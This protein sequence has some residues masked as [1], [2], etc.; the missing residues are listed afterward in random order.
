MK[1]NLK[2]NDRS[3][4]I[5]S[6]FTLIELLVVIAIIAIL[7]GML[8]PALNNARTRARSIKCISNLKQLGVSFIMYADANDS[9]Y[10]TVRATGQTGARPSGLE[11]H[12]ANEIFWWEGLQDAGVLPADYAFVQ[13][14]NNSI[15]KLS[16]Q[17]PELGRMT[18]SSSS[19]F[20]NY[21]MNYS[22]FYSGD[23]TKYYKTTAAAFP[24][25][26]ALLAEGGISSGT[27]KGKGPSYRFN[28][29]NET[30]GNNYMP[31]NFERHRK[32]Y[33]NILFFDGH[34]DVVSEKNIE[35]NPPSTDKGKL[36][37]R[38]KGNL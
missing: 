14:A 20:Y 38:L 5:G 10:P 32:D 28:R 12:V 7:A 1:N 30:D 31:I 8:L 3:N 9:F 4:T 22:A 23:A 35:E 33:C 34:A 13:T 19:Q 17:C 24:S 16:L 15:K 29:K 21:A 6:C 27:N 37:W 26:L 11:R 18:S 25:S 36:F 2:Q